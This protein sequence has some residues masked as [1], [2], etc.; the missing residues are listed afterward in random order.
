MKVMK[1]LGPRILVEEIEPIDDVTAAYKKAGLSAVVLESN[2][3]QPTSGKVIAVGTDPELQ[4]HVREGDT[5]IFSKHSGSNVIIEGRSLR[6]LEFHEI[7]TVTREEVNPSIPP[8]PGSERT[9]L[10]I[11]PLSRKHRS[12]L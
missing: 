8:S 11:R 6:C 4:E 10:P 1:P 5:V 9:P 12:P 7:I 3:P 2:K